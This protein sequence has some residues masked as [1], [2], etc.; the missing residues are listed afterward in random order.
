MT[1]KRLRE[2]IPDRWYVIEMLATEYTPAQRV[3]GEYREGYFQLLGL[4]YCQCEN[5]KDFWPLPPNGEPLGV[6]KYV[7]PT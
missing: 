7:N 3:I 5:V 2:L 4:N 1:K 6:L